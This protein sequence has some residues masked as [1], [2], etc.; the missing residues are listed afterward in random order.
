MNKKTLIV[1]VVVA[2]AFLW[3]RASREAAP[4]ADGA[5]V[6]YDIGGSTMRLTFTGLGG[7]QFLATLE[8]LD[9]RSG[10][11]RVVR[12]DTVDTRMRTPGGGAFE[13]GSLGPLWVPPGQVREGGNAHGARIDEL[14]S[15][16]GRDVGVV[17]ASVGIGAA[18]R[19][20]WLYDVTTGFLVGGSRGTA[21]SEQGMQFT[22]VA[23]NVE[24]L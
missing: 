24:G 21:V 22:L 6:T 5:F 16:E 13:L 14:R 1:L 7:D 8:D 9:D 12:V 11:P 2:A 18:L 15:W 3:V 23:S 10:S 19:G 17:T 20:E 4:L